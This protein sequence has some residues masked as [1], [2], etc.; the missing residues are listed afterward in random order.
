[1]ADNL[2][3]D[4]DVVIEVGTLAVNRVLAA[5]HCTERFP[6]SMSLRVDDNPRSGRGALGCV[7]TFGDP[8]ANQDDIRPR[9]ILPGQLVASD[10]IVASLDLIVNPDQISA[11]VTIVPSDLQGR[12]QLQLAPPTIDVTG[13]TGSN[14]TVR[15]PLRARYFPDPQSRPLAEFVRGELQ[16]TA[17]VDQVASPDPQ[18]VRAMLIDIRKDSVSVNLSLSW[19]SRA[20]TVED[21]TGINLLIRNALKTSFLPS[22]NRLPDN[23]NFLQFKTLLG[24][25][26]AVA[27]LLNIDTPRGNPSTMNRVFLDA[28]DDFAIVLGKDFVLGKFAPVTNKMLTAPIPPIPVDVPIWGHAT[29]T[30]SLNTV[31]AALLDEK[32]RMTVTGHAH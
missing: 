4:F 5:M 20:L 19:W 31:D 16:I 13:A 8:I 15:L 23:V 32:I 9:R 1:M 26:S 22:S 29:Y 24:S 11:D 14:V 18:N 28:G 6:H 21:F 17:P 12:V 2:T 3:G 10:L 7:D 27:G 25:P 30:V